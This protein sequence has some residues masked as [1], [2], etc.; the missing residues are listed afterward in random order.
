M[1][2]HT[3]IWV[4][5]DATENHELVA[6]SLPVGWQ[7]HARLRGFQSG[8]AAIAEIA[9]MLVKDITAELPD[10]VFMDFFMHQ[11][12]GAETTEQLLHLYH[13]HG[14]ERERP[15]II[16]H[17]SMASASQS[18]VAAGGDMVIPKRSRAG[19][20]P[21]IARFIPDLA[22]LNALGRAGEKRES[23]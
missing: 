15:M 18:I 19:I 4:V 3:V 16:G 22:A 21:G 14:R 23:P 9:R 17:S 11:L 10:L 1:P 7:D 13:L 6:S 8:E 12:H 5:D 20:S 2:R